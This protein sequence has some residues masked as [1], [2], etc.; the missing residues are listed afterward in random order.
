VKIV[1]QLVVRDDADVVDAHLAYH[2]NAGV[3]LILATDHDSSD[4]SSEILESYV[5]EGYAQRLPRSGPARDAEWRASM[6]RAAVGEHAAD[7]VI[8]SEV[9]EFWLPR[10]ES[11]GDVLVAI[12]ERYGVV[13]ALVRVFLPRPE[14]EGSF[15][16]RLTVRSGFGPPEDETEGRLDWALRP[17]FRAR[18]DI[19]LGLDREATLDGRVPLRA[20]YPIEVLRFPLRSRDQARRRVAG[21]SGPLD[22]RSRGERMLLSGGEADLD[23][24]WSELV[25]SDEA[26]P[27]GLA[28]GSLVVDERL[29][30]ALAHL[31]VPDPAGSSPRFIFPRAGSNTLRLR[32]PTV[33]VDVAYAAECAALR[34]VDFEPLIE[35]IAE[36]EERIGALEARFWPRVARTLARLLRR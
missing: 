5:R 36:L 23:E 30:E 8:D 6:V 28:D 22:A 15:A 3:D 7:W 18:E 27:A 24:S 25:V 33:V 31:R 12:P 11:L 9:D 34:E 17:V 14:H 29:R 13:Q 20:W 35:R 26:L 10:A 32:P 16:E 19:T 1:M 21:R 2:L 4:G